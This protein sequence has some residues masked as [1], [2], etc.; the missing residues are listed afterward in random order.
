MEAQLIRAQPLPPNWS[1][2]YHGIHRSMR[3]GLASALV[4]VGC[5]GRPKKDL[6]SAS[7]TPLQRQL[8]HGF[9]FIIGRT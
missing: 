7:G 3:S 5:R 6:S 8:R 4:C 9:P 1:V 2:T